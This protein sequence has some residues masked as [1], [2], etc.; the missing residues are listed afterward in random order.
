VPRAAIVTE[1]LKHGAG[2]PI[3]T[4]RVGAAGPCRRDE[5]EGGPGRVAQ[6]GARPH[7]VVQ[8]AGARH[9][10]CRVL[11]VGTDGTA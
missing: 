5:P 8:R 9:V 6:L 7:L 3:K 10:Q 4:S 2:D 11:G 1:S